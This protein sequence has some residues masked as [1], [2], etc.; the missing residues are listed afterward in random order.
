MSNCV[1]LCADKPG[2]RVASG[3]NTSWALV[4]LANRTAAEQ[5]FKASLLNPVRTPTTPF[6]YPPYYMYG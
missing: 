4:T 5:A 6:S 3:R 2:G 1:K